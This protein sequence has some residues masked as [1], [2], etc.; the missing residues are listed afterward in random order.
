MFSSSMLIELGVKSGAIYQDIQLP[1]GLYGHRCHL[2]YRFW[3]AHVSGLRNGL[4]TPSDNFVDDFL[5]GYF[6]HISNQNRGTSFCQRTAK[7]A[8]KQTCAASHH[9]DAASQVKG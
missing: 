2:F 7:L 1:K 3:I 4:P 5:S 8:T 6:I 9:C